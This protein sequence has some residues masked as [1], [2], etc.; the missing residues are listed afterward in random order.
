M[1]E[2]RRRPIN[3]FKEE[4]TKGPADGDGATMGRQVDAHDP[5]GLES[6]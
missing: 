2:G 5:P 4:T 3:S 1:C 6:C